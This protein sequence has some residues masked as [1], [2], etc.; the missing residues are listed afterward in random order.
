M[1]RQGMSYRTYQRLL[2]EAKD[3]GLIDPPNK[4][5]RKDILAPLKDGQDW[6]GIGP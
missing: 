4:I 1:R 5:T 3:Q 6:Y 2:K